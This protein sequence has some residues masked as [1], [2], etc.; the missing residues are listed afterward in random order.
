MAKA[1]D[2]PPISSREHIPSIHKIWNEG[3]RDLAIQKL[4]ELAPQ[5]IP[6]PKK[7]H[8]QLGMYY[9]ILT[10][11]NQALP[12][13]EKAYA[14]DRN[15][16]R[17]LSLASSCL[18]RTQRHQE[19]LD[20]ALVV[21]EAYPE[22]LVALD[23]LAA[24]YGH[25]GDFAKSRIYGE[26]SLEIKDRQACESFAR[27]Q[28]P[29][30]VGTQ[31]LTPLEGRKKVISFSLFGNSPRYLRGALQNALV[32][33]EMYPGW[34]LRFYVDDTVPKD[35]R[36]L[37]ETFGCE[38]C[39]QPS[40]QSLF[41]KLSWRFLV[42]DDAAVGRFLV[43]DCDSVFI[44]REAHTVKQWVDSGKSFHIIRDWQTHTDLILAGLWGGIA[45]V[46]P[47]M[48]DM[49]ASFI[50]TNSIQSL[51]IDQ[52]FLGQYVWPQIKHDCFISDSLF[53]SF[54]AHKIENILSDDEERIAM[55]RYATK[56][57][58]QERLLSPW[59]GKYPCLQRKVIRASCTVK[60]SFK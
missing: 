9:Y 22:H 8:L 53:T 35:F 52:R 37:L 7:Y 21:H 33:M 17:L 38:I 3:K 43:R 58:E 4:L 39:V 46:L 50:R 30:R 32:G 40:G 57:S 14:C 27:L 1:R 16:M 11:F 18:S 6:D 42:A 55:N 45:G 5:D 48:G 34:V 44:P 2:L 15:D 13:F 23:I 31:G 24:N 12:Q 20:A 59:I 10:R 60:V 49:I 54:G 25:L 56:N 51:T 47:G 28:Y 41:Q 19:A 29:A 36:D 26:K